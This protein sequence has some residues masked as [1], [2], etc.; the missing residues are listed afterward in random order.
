[1]P[2]TRLDVLHKAFRNGLTEHT[3]RCEVPLR[4]RTLAPS[5]L[6]VETQRLTS[7]AGLVSREVFVRSQRR[8]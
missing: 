7:T 2:A 8:E 1:M 4:G 5:L 6:C 3:C